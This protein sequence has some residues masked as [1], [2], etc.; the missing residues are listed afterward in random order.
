MVRFRSETV[1]LASCYRQQS[2]RPGPLFPP[3][4]T[5]PISQ[6]C[7]RFLPRP[8]SC[9]L[10]KRAVASRTQAGRKGVSFR[11]H[12]SL[13]DDVFKSCYYLCTRIRRTIG[14][15]PA[16]HSLIQPVQSSSPSPC[17]PGFQPSHVIPQQLTIHNSRI[18]TTTFPSHSLIAL[19]TLQVSVSLIILTTLSP[20]ARGRH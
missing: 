7:F 11:R 14:N 3:L 16:P 20:E 10:R 2:A 13:V 9:L 18:R 6:L 19:P 17:L 5:N 4:Q 15:C 12:F 8:D 1:Q